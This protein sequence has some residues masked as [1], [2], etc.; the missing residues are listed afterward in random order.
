MQCVASH[1]TSIAFQTTGWL[2]Q[3]GT[4]GKGVQSLYGEALKH[5]IHTPPTRSP[6]QRCCCCQSAGRLQAHSLI[7][8]AA[9]ASMAV[10]SLCLAH[11]DTTAGKVQ[12]Q[13]PLRAAW[14]AVEAS[15]QQQ[16]PASSK[17]AGSTHARK[18][19]SLWS[20]ARQRQGSISWAA[21]M[22]HGHTLRA[23][24]GPWGLNSLSKG[25]VGRP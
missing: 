9:A 15:H 12:T 25:R 4:T 18:V 23:A 6:A 19:C 14:A 16:K 5:P 7:E 1:C 10:A 11:R 17:P 21:R 2:R 22:V 20:A 13:A 3:F 8:H 24:S